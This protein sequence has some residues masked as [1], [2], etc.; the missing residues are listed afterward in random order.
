LLYLANI[1]TEELPNTIGDLS[2]LEE[3]SI[4]NCQNLKSLPGSISQL[5]KLT[6][7]ELINTGISY[8]KYESLKEE[9][10]ALE[11]VWR[12]D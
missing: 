11:I 3:L 8:D 4:Q 1:N 6:R 12:N 5:S 10:P 9:F 7:L 2:K